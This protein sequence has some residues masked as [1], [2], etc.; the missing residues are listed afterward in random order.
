MTRGRLMELLR[1]AVD[2]LDVERAQDDMVRFVRDPRTIDVWSRD[3]FR[4]VVQRIEIF[5]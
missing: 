4:E 1:Q 2:Q 5:S 3:F